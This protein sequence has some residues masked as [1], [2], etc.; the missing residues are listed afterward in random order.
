MDKTLIIVPAYNEQDVIETTVEKLK[1]FISANPE[2]DYIVIDDG[3]T[4]LT[5]EILTRIGAKHLKHCI[6]LGIGEPFK[7]G[8]RYGLK[9]NYTNYINFDADGQHRLDSLICLI[10]EQECDLV[11]G[12]RFITGTKPKSLRMI[13]SRL[14]SLIIKLKTG[15]Y[16]SDPTSGLILIRGK[17]FIDFYL[18]LAANK[19]EPALYPKVIKQ[20]K[21][22]EVSVKMEARVV[23]N[24][25]FNVYSSIHFMLEQIFEIIL[26]G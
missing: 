26:K 19:P 23:G 8:I 22:K 7:T 20:F 25:Y 21:I 4:D 13:G 24:S 9:K 15:V 3:S 16:L 11:V 1:Q 5:P 10:K 17:Q 18:S 2:F 6:N 12:S 14:L